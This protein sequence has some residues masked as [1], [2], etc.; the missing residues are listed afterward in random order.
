MK[1]RDLLGLAASVSILLFSPGRSYANLKITVNK[2]P[3]CGCCDAWVEHLRSAGFA[4]ETLD[5]AA[6]NRVKA[7]L[8]VPRELASCHTAE[9]DGYVI[10]GHVPASAIRRLLAERPQAKGL[11]VPNMPV[12]SPGMEVEGSPPEEYTVFL[13]GK[14]GSRPYAK[15]KGMQEIKS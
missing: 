9:V 6:I 10:E 12:G 14:F 15:F 8:G 1:R 13:F 7:K 3:N 11:A 2:D 5:S 4:T